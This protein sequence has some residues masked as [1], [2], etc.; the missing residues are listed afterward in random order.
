MMDD[1]TK[2]KARARLKRIEGQVAAL[3]RMLD[4][5]ADC[6]DVLLQISAAQGALGGAGQLI[7]GQHIESC[8][9]EALRHGDDA[10]RALKIEELVD[11]FSRYGR[12]G[13]R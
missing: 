11:V 10:E 13:S 5:D 1:K 2:R 4:A 7:L 6:V 3:G 12:M 9:G 8:V